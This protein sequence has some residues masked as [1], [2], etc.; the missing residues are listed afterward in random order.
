MARL[1]RAKRKKED[2]AIANPQ[3]EIGNAE[4]SRRQFVRQAAQVAAMSL[5]GVAA[6]DPI[7]D[8]VV[9]RVNELHGIDRMG[10]DVAKHLHRMGGVAWG[11]ETPEKPT[12]EYQTLSDPEGCYI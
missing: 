2:S 6:L 8:R 3:S 4:S 1:G 5:F 7:L 12:L 11:S 9:G 10:G